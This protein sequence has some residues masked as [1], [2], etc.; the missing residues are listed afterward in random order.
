MSIGAILNQDQDVDVFQ[1]QSNHPAYW[2]MVALDQ[3]D[4]NGAWNP[5]PETGQAAVP[6]VAAAIPLVARL[7]RR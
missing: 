4:A 2:R 5:A 7:M 1:V 6:G 3:V